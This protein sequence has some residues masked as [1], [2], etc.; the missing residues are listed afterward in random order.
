[1]N[2][3]TDKLIRELA[4]K[5][6]T[7][8]EHLWN[9]LIKQA[10]ISGAGNLITAIV[11]LALTTIAFIVVRKKASRTDDSEIIYMFWV[12]FFL[13]SFVMVGISIVSLSDAASAILNPEYWALKEVLKEIR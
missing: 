12:M 4:D 1:M 6:G 5:L 10:A 2:E 13:G 11:F 3:T 8:T 9:V 7:T